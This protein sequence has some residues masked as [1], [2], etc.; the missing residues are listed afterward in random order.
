MST[1]RIGMESKGKELSFLLFTIIFLL[2]GMLG[3][4]KSFVHA[5]LNVPN[6]LILVTDGNELFVG[7]FMRLLKLVVL[8]IQNSAVVL[9]VG[10][11]SI[12]IVNILNQNNS[13]TAPVDCP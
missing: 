4:A 9:A 8:L 2:T 10:E 1:H 5:G 11:I 12:P 3:V 13:I 6:A 7:F